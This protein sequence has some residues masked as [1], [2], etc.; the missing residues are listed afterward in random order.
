MLVAYI[1]GAMRWLPVSFS[2][3]DRLF[4]R[5]AFCKVQNEALF[6]NFEFPEIYPLREKE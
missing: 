2:L 6:L 4:N 1:S 5:L 3:L